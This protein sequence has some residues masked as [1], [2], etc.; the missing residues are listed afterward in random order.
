MRYIAYLDIQGLAPTTVK[1]YLAAI[2]AWA[3]SL[4]LREPVIWTPRVHLACKAL[5]RTHAPPR[6]V[7]PINFNTLSSMI[8]LLSPAK[9][10]M[11]IASALTL[12]FFACLR[13][14]ELCS[15][16][17]QSLAPTR[18][19]VQFISTGSSPIM[20]YSC[21]SSKNNV[22]GFKVHLGCSGVPVCAVCIMYHYFTHFPAPPS[23][24]LFR[25]SS[26]HQLTY[27][28]YNAWIKHLVRGVGLDPAN[29]STHS[30]RAG[31]ATQAAQTGLDSDTIK[32]LGRWRS[33][34]YLTYLRPP[35]ESYAALA[36][37][38]VHSS[39]PSSSSS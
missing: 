17:H 10:H 19:D 4:G 7:L 34:A 12:Q 22:H 3:V 27:E 9:D 36:P 20:V 15:G 24:P 5:V 26:G 28:A 31:A 30:V 32:R 25:L 6:Q 8:R 2:R 37:K 38:L 33:Q 23:D 1:N 14:S 29:Y 13:A 35:P 21:H 16:L 39:H 11:V 18:A